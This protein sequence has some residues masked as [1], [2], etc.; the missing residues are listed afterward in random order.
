MRK[1]VIKKLNMFFGKFVLAPFSIILLVVYLT[2][3]GPSDIN[4]YLEALESN[5]TYDASGESGF[6]EGTTSQDDSTFGEESSDGGSVEDTT[7][8]TTSEPTTTRPP[9]SETTTKPTTTKPTT[10]KPDQGSK[11]EETTKPPQ[12]YDISLEMPSATG[13]ATSDLNGYVIDYSN[14]NSGYVMVKATVDAE[15]V[16]QV[17]LGD[18]KGTVVGQYVLKISNN[19]VAIPL[20]KGNE[21]YCVR[22]MQKT[23][24][25]KY[26]EKNAVTVKPKISNEKQPYKIP[27]VYVY[28]LKSSTAVKLSYEICDGLTS[29]AQKVKAIY[30]YIVKNIKYDYAFA[31]TATAG[32]MDSERCL[33]NK[34]GICGDYSVLFATMCRAQG[35][36]CIVVE[37]Y[38]T[39]GGDVYHA[40]NQVYYDKEWHFYDT[41][42]DAS[43]GKGKN[44]LE[45]YR[46]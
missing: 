41:T 32:Y 18:K 15:A 44:Y 11:E 45:N 22:I 39:A 12:D 33:K 1:D 35:I 13:V 6:E 42:F 25:G 21:T 31:K 7:K 29:D 8:P 4:N 34:S 28:Y 20:T 2:S 43:G 37:G 27:N 24:S 19:F 10:T 38:V 5:K 26:T 16:V 23:T 30:N 46:Y 14:I 36:P 3:C 9:A 40:W 17:R